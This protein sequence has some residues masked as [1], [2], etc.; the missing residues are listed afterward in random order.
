[1]ASVLEEKDAIR[2]LLHEYCYRL[3]QHRFVELAELFTEDGEWITPYARAKGRAEMA[4]LWRRVVPAKGEGP[5]RLHYVMNTIISIHGVQA[6]AR[7]NYLV[8]LQMPDGLAPSV[9][10]TYSDVLRKD[11]GAW[12]IERR[13]LIHHIKGEMGLK[14]AGA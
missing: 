9:C 3:D 2:E 4:A 8:V 7:S 12:R 10:G 11:E 5:G 6:E 1:M 14:I 13:E